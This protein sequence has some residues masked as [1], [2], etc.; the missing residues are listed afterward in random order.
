MNDLAWL[1]SY[2]KSGNTWVRLL[3]SA[4]LTGRCDINSIMCST[5]DTYYYPY[6][7]VI[8]KQFHEMENWE[9]AACAAAA[10]LHIPLAI[11]ERP[12][13]IKTHHANLRPFGYTVIPHLLCEKA[14]YMIRDPRDV[15]ISYAKHVG[16]SVDDAIASMGD[17]SSLLVSE[18]VPPQFICSWSQHVGSWLNHKSV[19]VM[20]VKYEDIMDSP[21][22]VFAGILGFLGENPIKHRVEKAVELT[23][24]EKLREQEAKRGFNEASKKTRFF[25]SGGSTWRNILSNKQIN[26]ITRDHGKMMNAVGYTVLEAVA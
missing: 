6:Q 14:I 13:L 18:K 19:E 12:L 10:A 9:W 26:Q 1:A 23:S 5:N 21:A 20:G 11:R 24:I 15:A 3:M 16:G 25:G 22:D 8:P 4:Y 17:D 7:S 2:P